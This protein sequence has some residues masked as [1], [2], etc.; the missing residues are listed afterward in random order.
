MKSGNPWC[1]DA[2]RHGFECTTSA[3]MCVETFIATVN[4]TGAR[5]LGLSAL[6][7]TTMSVQ[8]R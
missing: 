8:N 5:I 3:S 4:A 1:H 6:L 2:V 7:T